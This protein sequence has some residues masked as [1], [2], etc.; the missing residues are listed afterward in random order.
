MREKKKNRV[1]VSQ[2]VFAFLISVL[3]LMFYTANRGER[4]HNK[5]SCNG[6][7]RA[8]WKRRSMRRKSMKGRKKNKARVMEAKKHNKN[9]KN[10]AVLRW[11]R[12]IRN[13]KSF[14]F[15]F[16]LLAVF[17]KEDMEI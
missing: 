9:K 3:S 13:S 4:Q 17:E 5:K 7:K 6:E 8:F 16:N 1:R 2:G 12:R 11:L 10:A 14:S 15:F